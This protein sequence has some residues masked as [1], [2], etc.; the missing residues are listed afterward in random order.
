MD[1]SDEKLF[2]FAEHVEIEIGNKAILLWDKKQDIA[3]AI[4]GR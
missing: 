2:C 1:F 3:I 4:D